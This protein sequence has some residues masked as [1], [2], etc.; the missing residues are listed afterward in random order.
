MVLIL[1]ELP[2]FHTLYQKMLDGI[3][4][5]ISARNIK[6]AVEKF[7]LIHDSLSVIVLAARTQ[8][9]PNT[10]PLVHKFREKFRGPMIVISC[11]AN[12]RRGMK[13]AGCDYE[14][15][16]LEVVDLILEILQK[17]KSGN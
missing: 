6:E 7:N 9:Q 15:D 16:K 10:I 14:A 5:T 3:A 12:Y 8:G 4:T 2:E 17:Q 13:M 11:D 1:E